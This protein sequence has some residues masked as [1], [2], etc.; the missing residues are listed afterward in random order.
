MQSSPES[1]TLVTQCLN[2]QGGLIVDDSGGDAEGRAVRIGELARQ[3]DLNP[4]TIR[5]Y[6]SIGLLPQPAR[7][8]G[9]YRMYDETDRDRLLFIRT[10]QVFG[11]SLDEIAE[12]LAF[13]ERD[14]PPCRYVAE[15]IARHAEEVE[16]RI[17]ELQR[18]GAELEQ[19]KGRA[20]QLDLDGRISGYCPIIEHRLASASTDS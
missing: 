19:L 12:I 14:E 15:L 11:L 6:E 7:T 5:Y 13:R 3:L 20:A 10:A 4:K 9:G 8:P 1:S 17:A 2:G 18:L 16:Q